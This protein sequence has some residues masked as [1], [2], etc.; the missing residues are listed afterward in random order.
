MDYDCGRV[1][2]IGVVW[3]DTECTQRVQRPFD[4]RT[5]VC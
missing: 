2:L 4:H 1:N 5:F 3:L